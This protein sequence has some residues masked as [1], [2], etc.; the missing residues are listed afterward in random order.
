MN[1]HPQFS[2]ANPPV[3]KIV[4]IGPESTGKSTLCEQLA[5][6]FS[7]IWCR[8]YAR[9]Y[10]L[11]HGT[12]YGYEDL[13]T[14]ARGQLKGEDQ[15]LE[16]ALSATRVRQQSKPPLLFIDT[17]MY[18]M[19]VWSEFVFGRCHPFVLDEIVKRKYDGY[20]LCSPDLDWVKDELREYPDLETRAQLYHHYKDI[21]V[22][23]STPWFEVHG[24]DPQRT[25]S[26]IAWVEQLVQGAEKSFTENRFS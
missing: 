9:A 13:L 23:Q 5:S 2:L 20:L 7:T 21:L 26:A 22:N 14:I 1:N 10:L 15:A 3:I 8:E 6:H 11:E 18:V 16:E 4:A 19:K 24:Q 25:A 17:D 12:D